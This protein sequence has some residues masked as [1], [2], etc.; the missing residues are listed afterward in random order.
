MSGPVTAPPAARREM[1]PVNLL[2]SRTLAI[3][4]V[5]AGSILVAGLVGWL[6]AGA[7]RSTAV[8]IGSWI[9]RLLV[10]DP[11]AVMFL[12]LA[13]VTLTPVAQL[14]AALVGF[15]T[16]GDRRHAA[17]TGGVLA[18]VAGSA[19]LALWIGEASR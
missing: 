16:T 15:A 18:I 9:E 6:L 4:S 3:G 8:D 14:I 19:A 17:L 13:L 11:A 5:A 2:V 1:D 7:P 10:L 12:G